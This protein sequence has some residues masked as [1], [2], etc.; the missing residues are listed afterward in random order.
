VDV[1]RALRSDEEL[2]ERPV[3]LISSCDEGEVE[4]RDAG[5]NLFLQKPIDIVG[6]PDVVA[7]L[8]PHDEPPPE[9]RQE[10]AA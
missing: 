2:R 3:I 4:W 8:L 7:R 10:L 5:A 1:T 9:Q 6:L